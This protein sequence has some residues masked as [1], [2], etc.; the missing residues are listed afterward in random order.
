MTVEL[1]IVPLLVGLTAALG[2]GAG[3][4]KLIDGLLK[5]RSGMSAK[6]SQRKVDIVTQRDAAL[7]REDRAW[8]LVD[9]EAEKRRQLQEYA[10]RLRRQLIEEGI[11]PDS[12]PVLAQTITRAELNELRRS[13]E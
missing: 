9:G 5:I 8:R 12:E 2:G 13:K 11:E 7:A 4:A 10:A 1:D 3:L 6:E